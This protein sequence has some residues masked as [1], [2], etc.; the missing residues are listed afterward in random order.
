LPVD[1][2]VELPSD[3]LWAFADHGSVTSKSVARPGVPALP[4]L[5]VSSEKTHSILRF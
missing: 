4:A 2:S 1:G 5:I 3:E